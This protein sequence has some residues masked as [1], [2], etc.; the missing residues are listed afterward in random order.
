MKPHKFI[1][2]GQNQW[3][4]VFC[5]YCGIVAHDSSL[6][7]PIFDREE[8]QKKIRQGCPLAPKGGE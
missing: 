3:L 5:E 8:V 1:S 4:V 6:N 7:N 2:R